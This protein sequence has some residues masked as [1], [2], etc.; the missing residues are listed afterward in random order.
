MKHK[1]HKASDI[2]RG[3]INFGLWGTPLSIEKSPD[4]EI[5]TLPTGR[6][7][8][9]RNQKALNRAYAGTKKWPAIQHPQVVAY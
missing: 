6:R 8:L 7:C 4:G 5:V 9:I 3:N 1:A 2:I